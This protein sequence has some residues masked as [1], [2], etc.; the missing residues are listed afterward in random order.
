LGRD[1][2]DGLAADSEFPHQDQAVDTG[3]DAPVNAPV[4]S[5]IQK[6]AEFSDLIT[7]DAADFLAPPNTTLES[8]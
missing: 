4:A 3:I 7:W 6:P 8:S 2:T 1:T 5:A